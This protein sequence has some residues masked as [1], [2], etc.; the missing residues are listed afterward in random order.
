MIVCIDLVATEVCRWLCEYCAFPSIMDQ[1]STTIPIINKHG[2]YIKKLID[3]L[4][5]KGAEVQLYFQ[6][7]EVGELDIG[8]IRHLFKIIDSEITISTN[9]LFLDRGYHKDPVIREYIKQIFW[10]VNPTCDLR[11]I[12][13]FHDED[14]KIV[15]GVVHKDK[16]T[17]ESFNNYTNLNIEYS[18]IENPINEKSVVDVDIIEKCRNYHNDITIDLVNEKICLCIRTFKDITIP[19][20]E[21]NLLTALK[22]F[23]GVLY[24]LP[25]VENSL[26]Y[27]C[28][29]LCVNRTNKN[30]I[31]TQIKLMRI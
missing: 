8:V 1:K 26:C 9:G 20:T 10:H 16:E 5:Q 11:P 28:C 2:W 12:T 30:V 31:E 19:L 3:K 18:E 7:G 24:D 29:R 22:T 15:R 6:G 4:K 14:I 21:E 17:L 25:A 27:S 13:D 23:P